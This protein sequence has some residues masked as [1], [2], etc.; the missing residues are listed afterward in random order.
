MPVPTLGRIRRRAAVGVALLALAGA[1]LVAGPRPASAVVS[2][3]HG[4][5][6]TVDGFT[7]WYGSYDM[8]GLGT[9]W[10]IDHGIHAPDPAYAYRAADV[11]AIPVRT[12]TAMAWVLGR[13]ATGTDR[14]RHAAVMLVL[15]DLMGARYPS[16]DLDVARLRPTDLAG[17]GGQEAA[18]LDLARR[19]KADGLAHAHLRGPLAVQLR[20]GVPDAHGTVPITVRLVDGAGQ[21]VAGLAVALDASAGTTLLSRSVTTGPDGTVRTSARPVRLPLTVRASALAPGLELAAWA[22][23]TRTAQRVARPVVRPLTAVAT[24]AAPATTTTTVAP[25]TTTLPPTTTT[26]PPTTTTVLPTT[27]TTVPP[28][29]TTLASTTTAPAAAVPATTTTTAPPVTVLSAPPTMPTLPRT[30]I[31]AL[32]LVLLALGFVLLG[33]AALEARRPQVMGS[34]GIGH[35]GDHGGTRRR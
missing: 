1:V 20:V 10:C 32:G 28:T 15:H 18:V 23:T 11:S 30:G 13:H 6:A 22:P 14:V 31:D 12:R 29:A 24:L 19:A 8:A 25:T 9:A 3:L 35:H 26:L 27:T 33:T 17:F 21:G 16:G 5:R 34:P 4:Y 2:P 7:S